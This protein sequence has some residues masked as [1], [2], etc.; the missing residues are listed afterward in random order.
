MEGLIHVSELSWKERVSKPEEVL[1]P[2]TDVSGQS[3]GR[4]IRQKEKLSL[5]L[6]RAG[7][8]PWDTIKSKYP[9][10]SRLQGPITHL[11]PFGAFIMLPEGIEGWCISPI[12]PGPSAPKHP[13]EFVAVGQVIEVVVMDVKPDAE[14]IVLSLKHVHPDPFSALRNGQTVSGLRE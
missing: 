4:W 7:A 9:V 11:T 2:N 3:V 13:P 14:K 6:K 10:G 12:C 8:S 5:S 1:K